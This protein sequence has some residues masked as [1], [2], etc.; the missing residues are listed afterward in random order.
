MKNFAG[1]LFATSSQ[2][3]S[4]NTHTHTYGCVRE[5]IRTAITVL[6][7]NRRRIT[8][9][10]HLFRRDSYVAQC[11]RYKPSVIF[12]ICPRAVITRFRKR[13]HTFAHPTFA[14]TCPRAR[15]TEKAWKKG[16]KQFST[17]WWKGPGSFP[18]GAEEPG[19]VVFSTVISLNNWDLTFDWSFLLPVM[20]RIETSL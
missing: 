9:S 8:F 14:S 11:T 19:F 15:R 4:R 16:D 13:T 3:I 5:Y 10:Y 2:Q 20:W 12:R 1:H 18:A 6:R 17:Q 7:L